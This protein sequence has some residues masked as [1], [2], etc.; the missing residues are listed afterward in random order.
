MG[1]KLL[2]LILISP[3]DYP[4]G[5][6]TEIPAQEDTDVRNFYN[7]RDSQGSSPS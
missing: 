2:P 3:E 5:I 6:K 7:W 1:P 4:R